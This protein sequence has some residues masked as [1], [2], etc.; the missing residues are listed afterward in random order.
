MTSTT[1]R[2]MYVLHATNLFVDGVG[3]ELTVAD[4][5]KFAATAQD[6][7]RGKSREFVEHFKDDLSAMTNHAAHVRSVLK[8]IKELQEEYLPALKAGN[9]SMRV[10][11]TQAMGFI[12]AEG[13]AMENLIR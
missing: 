8:K 7:I 10:F 9:S 3:N 4:F 13:E 12:R 11:A 6:M 2:E 1:S 5:E